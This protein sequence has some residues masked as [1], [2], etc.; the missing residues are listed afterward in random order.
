MENDVKKA[1]KLAT[2]DKAAILAA[3]PPDQIEKGTE[4]FNKLISGKV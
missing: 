3:L 4:L 1:I 2:E